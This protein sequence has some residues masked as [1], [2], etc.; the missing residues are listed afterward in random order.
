MS[1]TEAR[2]D[3]WEIRFICLAKH[4]L[5]SSFSSAIHPDRPT[6]VWAQQ[7]HHNLRS[8]SKR[9]RKTS[10]NLP[11]FHPDARHAIVNMSITKQCHLRTSMSR[12]CESDFEVSTPPTT[13]VPSS[14]SIIKPKARLFFREAVFVHSDGCLSKKIFVLASDIFINRH[15]ITCLS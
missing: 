7:D 11:A 4:F 13:V 10:S 1:P 3:V 14:K 8:R 9:Q 2:Q 5:M 12:T 15:Y 6:Q